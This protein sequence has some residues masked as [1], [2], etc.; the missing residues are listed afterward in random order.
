MEKSTPWVLLL[1]NY[2]NFEVQVDFI[3]HKTKLC[4]QQGCLSKDSYAHIS[5]FNLL[6][7]AVFFKFYIKTL[8]STSVQYKQR[9]VEY[10]PPSL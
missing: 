3:H 10:T 5:R 1:R 7:Y 6:S 4:S 8:Y 9:R 2:G